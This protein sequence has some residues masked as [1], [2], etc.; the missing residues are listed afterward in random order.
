[1]IV[2]LLF[3]CSSTFFIFFIYLCFAIANFLLSLHVLNGAVLWA[4]CGCRVALGV[5][6]K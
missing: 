1:M 5:E 6:S 2:S 3:V 4:F